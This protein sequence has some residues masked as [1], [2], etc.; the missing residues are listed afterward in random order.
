VSAGAQ[1]GAAQAVTVRRDPAALFALVGGGVL[2][3]EALLASLLFGFGDPSSSPLRTVLL[4]TVGALLASGAA[5]VVRSAPWS[6]SLL[7]LLAASL[8][9]VAQLTLFVQRLQWHYAAWFSKPYD[10]TL[11]QTYA[12]LLAWTIAAAPLVCAAALA[13]RQA[14]RSRRG[15]TG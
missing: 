10:W 13:L 3:V 1:T 15:H 7:C 12:P 2:L 4:L 8:V 14:L 9:G 11:G 6:A 5:L